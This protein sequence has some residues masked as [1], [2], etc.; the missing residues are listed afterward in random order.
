MLISKDQLRACIPSATA[1]NIEAY[2]KPLNDTCEKYGINTP[3]RIA[4]FLAQ[5]AHESGSLRYSTELAS[6][7]AYDVGKLAISLGNTPEDDGDGEKYKGRGLIQITGKSN[8]KAVGDALGAD[9]ITYPALLCRPDFAALSAGWYWNS[10]VLNHYADIEDFKTITKKINGG[11][12]GYIDRV[13]HWLRARK[14]L[15]LPD[16]KVTLTE[17][18][19]KK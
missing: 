8:Y 2:L 16:L 10:R 17:F 7:A 9:F 15:G 4:A 1:Q 18:A 6:G 12:N 3:K 13:T 19:S 11:Y 14:I 5:L